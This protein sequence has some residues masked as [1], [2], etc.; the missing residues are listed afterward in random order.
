MG[1]F[2]IDHAFWLLAARVFKIVQMQVVHSTPAA[3]PATPPAMLKIS[4]MYAGQ[5]HKRMVGRRTNGAGGMYLSDPACR[6][7]RTCSRTRVSPPLP[8]PAGPKVGEPNCHMLRQAP[9]LLRWSQPS[10]IPLRCV[11][12]VGLRRH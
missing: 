3:P 12:R 9:G 6:A 11:C 10:E 7:I 4:A 8:A 2:E 5:M 1:T